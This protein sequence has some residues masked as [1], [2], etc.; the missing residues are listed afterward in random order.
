[1]AWL[2]ELSNSITGDWDL[3]LLTNSLNSASSAGDNGV[4]PVTLVLRKEGDSKRVFEKITVNLSVPGLVSR[5]KRPS[6]FG[7]L[8][9]APPFTTL[10]VRPVPGAGLVVR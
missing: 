9:S 10:L 8:N 5:V 1:C 3:Y 4:S 6:P 2:F 7:K